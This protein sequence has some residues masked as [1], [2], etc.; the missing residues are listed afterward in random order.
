MEL[1]VECV[2]TII[3]GAISGKSRVAIDNAFEKY[4]DVF[5]ER[6]IVEQRFREVIDIIY[7]NFE[8]SS[9]EFAFF[10]NTLIY[11][12]FSF[13]YDLTFRLNMPISKSSRQRRLSAADIGGIEHASKKIQTR[14]T[15]VPT[16]VLNAT[17]RRTTNPKERKILFK[18]LKSCV[19]NAK[20]HK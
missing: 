15:S 18:Y 6:N 7:K 13:I 19:K 8:G 12:F 14:S 20:T 10:K 9:S 5:K 11:T 17:D 3:N 2:L 16:D 4:D 1:T